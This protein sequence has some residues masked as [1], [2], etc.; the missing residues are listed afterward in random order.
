MGEHAGYPLSTAQCHLMA[1]KPLCWRKNRQLAYWVDYKIALTPGLMCALNLLFA[2]RFLDIQ[3]FKGNKCPH[4]PKHNLIG[5]FL[6]DGIKTEEQLLH[7]LLDWIVHGD[8]PFLKVTNTKQVSIPILVCK[9]EDALSLN[10]TCLY[11]NATLLHIRGERKPGFCLSGG[12][13]FKVV[14]RQWNTIQGV[15][16]E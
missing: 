6:H 16:L 11:P 7:V 3:L 9:R 10:R 4:L 14:D 15:Q 5:G 12:V 8:D 1:C 13:M 2:K